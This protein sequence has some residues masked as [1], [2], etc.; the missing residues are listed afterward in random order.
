MKTKTIK[1]VAHRL[2]EYPEPT[3]RYRGWVIERVDNRDDGG[4]AYWAVI[5][6]DWRQVDAWQTL[7]ECKAQ[8]DRY[9]DVAK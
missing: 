2:P 4:R 9:E 7:W 6:E 3:Y 8:V 1:H 5:D